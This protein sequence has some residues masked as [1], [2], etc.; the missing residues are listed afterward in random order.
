MA[1]SELHLYFDDLELGQEWVSQGRTI[2]EADIVN[3]AGLSGD[4]NP[5]HV[6]HAFA[7]ET[8]FRRPIAH[9]LL[10]VSIASGLGVWSPPMRTVAFI[11][12]RNWKF[13]EPIFIGDTLH[14]RTKVL[15]KEPRGRGR[16]GMVAW[17]RQLVNQEGK[18]VQEGVTVTLVEGRGM[19]REG[20]P[21]DPLS[22]H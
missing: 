9:G 6:D 5:I 16:R 1:F 2:T 4:Y 20:T 13:L 10:G 19:P 22:P 3:Y 18:V 11:E 7:G 21:S 15:E 14:L 17:F 12:I 8:I